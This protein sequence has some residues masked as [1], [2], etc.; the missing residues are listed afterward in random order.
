M[1]FTA[2]ASTI[3]DARGFA[4]IEVSR[5]LKVP[6]EH[7]E[8]SYGTSRAIREARLRRGIQ[9]TSGIEEVSRTFLE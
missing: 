4:A 8:C 7:N 5:A 6:L 1:Y 3:D 2:D 9:A